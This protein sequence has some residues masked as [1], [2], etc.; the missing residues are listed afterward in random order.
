MARKT[1]LCLTLLV[2]LLA[3][4]ALAADRPVPRGEQEQL[5]ALVGD[6]EELIGRL[7]GDRRPV[8]RK[9]DNGLSSV[10]VPLNASVI[11]S[12]TTGRT[13]SGRKSTATFKTAVNGHSKARFKSPSKG[14]T[15]PFAKTSVRYYFWWCLLNFDA[16]KTKQTTHKVK[17]PD[18]QVLNAV[19]QIEY[20]GPALD[21]FVRRLEA[22]G[23][24]GEYTHT[25]KVKSGGT[26]KEIFFAQ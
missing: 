14:I 10:V 15:H 12:L 22:L 2:A 5:E 1:L 6:L 3:L 23:T 20:E 17:G 18:G 16:T 7:D 24:R 25:V 9:L 26:A 19:D 13:R 21:C 11:E 4:P 8:F